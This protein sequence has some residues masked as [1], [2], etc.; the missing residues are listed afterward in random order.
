[1]VSE[2]GEPRFGP[3]HLL[4][5]ERQTGGIP[6]N[7]EVN[8]IKM[9]NPTDETCRYCGKQAHEYHDIVAYIQQ[10]GDYGSPSFVE[11]SLPFCNGVCALHYQQDEG[12]KK[13]LRAGF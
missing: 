4:V 12:P 7:K 1:M 6:K 5:G 8:K 13:E 3:H 2:F 10:T 9:S 11:Q